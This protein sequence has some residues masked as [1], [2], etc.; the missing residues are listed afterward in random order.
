MPIYWSNGADKGLRR[1]WGSGS[2]TTQK[3][4]R[5]TQR[6]LQLAASQ[7]YSIVGL[8][9]H[10]EQLQFSKKDT[11]LG[12]QREVEVPRACSPPPTQSKILDLEETWKTAAASLDRLLLL[13]TEQKKKY[14]SAID[15]RSSF[16]LRHCMVQSFLWLLSRRH[17]FPNKTQRELAC[18]TAHSFKRGLNTG[19]MIIKWTKSWIQHREIPDTHAGHHKHK[20][21]WMDDEDVVIAVRDFIQHQGESE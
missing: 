14:G 9:E 1:P 16:Y 6:E 12:A 17:Q 13:P 4:A 20:F 5:R 3:R 8:F 7:S 11:N 19:R 15:L 18:I 10:Q 21:T 2:K